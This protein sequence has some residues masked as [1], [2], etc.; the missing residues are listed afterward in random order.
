ME[1][2][3]DGFRLRVPGTYLWF[4]VEEG[5][6]ARIRGALQRLGAEVAQGGLDGE[7]LCSA[8]GM[9]VSYHG[10]SERMQAEVGVEGGVSAAACLGALLHVAARPAAEASPMWLWSPDP[11]AVAGQEAQPA[12]RLLRAARWRLPRGRAREVLEALMLGVKSLDERANVQFEVHSECVLNVSTPLTV[13]SRADREQRAAAFAE[14]ISR[15]GDPVR[16]DH[17]TWG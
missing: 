7:E 15:L 10:Q 17:V 6:W 2:V 5:E 16:A 11:F 9:S 1:A 12:E 14:L 13:D 3:E 8:V 4:N